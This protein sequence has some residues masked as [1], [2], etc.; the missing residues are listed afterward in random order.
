MY[1]MKRVVFA[2]L[3]FFC[4]RPAHGE[5]P[6]GSPS[7][8]L[9]F[10]AARYEDLHGVQRLRILGPFLEYS[11]SPEDDSFT[12]F[13]PLFSRVEGDDP[14]A[15]R[16]EIVWPITSTKRLE[17]EV[18]GRFLL[19][20]WRRHD[21][22]DPESR[23]HI[24]VLPVYFQGR[25]KH[26]DSYFA[27]FPLG[28]RIHEFLLQDRIQF[29]LF[30]VFADTERG[31]VETR[32]FIWPVYATTRSE[33]LY[34]FRVF[35]FYGQLKREDKYN[36]RFVLWP[37]WTEAEY[38][39][40]GSSGWSYILFP[41]YGRI[42][43]E[44]QDTIMLVPPIVR[45]S[46]SERLNVV[47]SPWPFI[48][49]KTGEVE[50]L[51]LWPLFGRRVTRGQRTTFALWPLIW[52]HRVDRGDGIMRRSTVVPFFYSEVMETRP[53][54]PE[55]DPEV[56]AAYRKIWPLGSYRREGDESRFRT[57]DLWPLKDAPVV[58]RNFAP[59]WTLYSRTRFEDNVDSELL[60]GLYRRR[61]RGEES[62][63]TSVFP[64]VE[65]KRD[66]RDEDE[67]YRWSLLK[68][69]IGYEREGDDRRVRLLYLL[70][71][72]GRGGS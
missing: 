35:P 45:F 9:G 65:W 48:Q 7:F 14:A 26:G 59:F 40:P 31:G 22:E 33:P 25:D 18:S 67:K 72:G 3:L 50:Q 61:V 70:R 58:E 16:M 5:E 55:V 44:D 32:H 13:R 34:R 39:Y 66:E 37:I 29:L 68:G 4:M 64:L 28:G 30:P 47:N 11:V 24:R 19:A 23:Y 56:T 42:K 46:R 71:L 10:I 8:D 20:Y 1:G 36:K 63:Y 43:L 57:L 51:Y 60:W 15:Y 6:G 69:L 21:V 49:I 2:C 12:A 27:V 62:A 17:D 54:G 41:V 52:N 38:Y 53:V